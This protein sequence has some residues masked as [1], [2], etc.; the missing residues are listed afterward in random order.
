MPFIP[1]TEEETALMLKDLGVQSIHDL[2]AE[3]SLN[4]PLDL[5]LPNALNEYQIQKH[6]KAHAKKIRP[7][8]SFVGGGA[9]EHYIPSAVWQLVAR[10][11]FLTAYTPYQPEVSQGNL[12][13]IYE[14]QTMMARLMSHEVSNASLYD[15]A[16]AVAEAILM[17]VRIK[18]LKTAHVLVPGN[19]HPH[20]LET[21]QTIINSKSI[22]IEILDY[23]FDTGL[24]DID[25]L[26]SAIR[27]N[28]CA[29]VVAQPNFFGG[30]EAVHD[31]SDRV[32]THG[33][34]LIAC[35][36][37][38][39]CALL[40]PPGEWGKQGADIAVGE[41][42]PLG[43]PLMGGGPYLGFL[44]TQK[45]YIRQMP[46]RLVGKT[47]DNEGRIGYVLT[48]QTREQHIRRSKATS[49]ICTNQGLMV[50]AATIYLSL[51]GAFGLR[52]V[53][54]K[55]HEQAIK[56]KEKLLKLNHVD[57]VFSSPFF[58]EFVIKISHA[59]DLYHQLLKQDIWAGLLLETYY[60]SLK[61]CILV[62]A[63]ETKSDDEISFFCD[64]IKT[65][66]NKMS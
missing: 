18:K 9:Y 27:P 61:D 53:A 64:A 19:M 20:Y 63:T 47:L 44:T 10:G 59:K 54:E 60:P 12:Q 25:H 52:N 22:D 5:N 38:L 31:I 65:Y 45:A 66:M 37:P 39:S 23:S 32:H 48:L 15:G 11:E 56:L 41:G 26:E 55:C 4:K 13:V 7:I 49:N 50:T 62:C 58:H 42:Q 57:L 17:A 3:I 24:L 1:H 46:G 51:M 40:T 2:F 6:M 30:L 33:L 16:T 29:V 34:L 35:V 36:N 8:M 21:I 14:Y 28:T 43:L